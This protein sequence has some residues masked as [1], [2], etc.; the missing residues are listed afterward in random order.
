MSR[1]KNKF[2]QL[3]S[4]SYELEESGGG[5]QGN[6]ELEVRPEQLGAFVERYHDW[7]GRALAVLPEAHRERFRSEYEGSWHTSKIKK[8]LE[9]PGEVNVLWSE[10]HIT[11]LITYWLYPNDKT[12][13]VP[14]LAQRQILVEARQ[15]PARRGQRLAL[16]GRP[17]GKWAAGV[18]ATVASGVILYLL[19]G[20]GS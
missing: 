15:Q 7:F 10:E 12:F 14:L 11:P 13:R 8:F 19:I 5:V 18:L 3:I 1:K 16:A 9:S 17:V 4:E 20:P 6:R 2:V